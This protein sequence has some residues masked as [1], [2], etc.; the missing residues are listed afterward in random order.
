VVSAVI[1]RRVPRYCIVL[2]AAV[3]EA[4]QSEMRMPGVHLTIAPQS[5][6]HHPVV[7]HV[8]RCHYGP[9]PFSAG[10]P[11]AAVSSQ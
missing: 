7:G 6:L 2:L 8:D 9:F 4:P 3:P 5:G 10:S 1:A 11:D